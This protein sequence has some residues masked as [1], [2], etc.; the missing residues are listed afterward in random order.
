MKRILLFAGIFFFLFSSYTYASPPVETHFKPFQLWRVTPV[1]SSVIHNERIELTFNMGYNTWYDDVDA[2]RGG[3]ILTTVGI[4]WVDL[5]F[6]RCDLFFEVLC[7]VPKKGL[8]DRLWNDIS[9]EWLFGATMGFQPN[10]W[11][12]MWRLDDDNPANIWLVYKQNYMWYHSAEEWLRIDTASNSIIGRTFVPEYH[13][14]VS[15]SLGLE[16][17]TLYPWLNFQA[18]FGAIW[19]EDE[20]LRGPDPNYPRGMMRRKGPSYF[21]TVDVKFPFNLLEWAT[22]KK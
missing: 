20:W 14:V 22:E 11:R 12:R 2:G 8:G 21:F 1:D 5:E 7:L 9:E 10:W 19:R 3:L 16:F 6:K 4:K 17:E 13:S 18:S 15:M